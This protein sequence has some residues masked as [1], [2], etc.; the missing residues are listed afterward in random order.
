MKIALVSKKNKWSNRLFSTLFSEFDTI[1]IHRKEDLEPNLIKHSPDWVFVF[2]WSYII[3]KSI[4]TKYR[5]VTF[6]TGNLPNDRGGSPIQNQILS[7]K[8]FSRVNAIVVQDPI[9]SGDVYCSKEISL[10]GSL[11]DI[12]STITRSVNILMLYCIKTNPTPRKQVGKS[13][14]YKR[15]KDNMLKLTNIESIYDQIRMLDGESYPNTYL[16]VD[17]FRLDFSR[18]TIVDGKILSDVKIHKI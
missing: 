13:S 12:W 11:H 10:Q 6:H 4:Y 16:E 17:G 14:T 8:T 7:G 18:A 9:D 15:K 1:F 5:C 3:D 2:H